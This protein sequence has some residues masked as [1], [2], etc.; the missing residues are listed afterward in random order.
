MQ[1]IEPLR[2]VPAPGSMEFTRK[3]GSV[4]IALYYISLLSG[5][6]IKTKNPNINSRDHLVG[7]PT[8]NDLACE[9]KNRYGS[10]KR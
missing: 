4:S 2:D 10:L 3:P 6:M 7:R 8:R 1:A 9:K 5:N